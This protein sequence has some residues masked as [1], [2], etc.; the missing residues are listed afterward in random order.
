MRGLRVAQALL[1][2]L[3]AP[4]LVELV[5]FLDH[6][7]QVAGLDEV[8]VGL[9]NALCL[10]LLVLLC[11]HVLASVRR[12]RNGGGRKKARKSTY[13][14][15]VLGLFA[16][17]AARQLAGAHVGGGLDRRHGDCRPVRT[18]QGANNNRYSRGWVSVAV[19][20]RGVGRLG[21][22][23]MRERQSRRAV[24]RVRQATMSLS[25]GMVVRRARG[26]GE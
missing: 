15:D 10:H 25:W 14:V 4:H 12:G 3:H 6:G 8:G 22:G 24:E 21:D 18:L 5:L 11:A 16:G 7:E 13:L 23:N 17:H 19:A 26:E 20:T 2:L 9:G 1:P